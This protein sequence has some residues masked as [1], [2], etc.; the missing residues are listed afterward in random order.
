MAVHVADAVRVFG[1]ASRLNEDGA[2]Y[3]KLL[4]AGVAVRLVAD[5]FLLD[6]EVQDPEVLG[7]VALMTSM[8]ESRPFICTQ[9][10]ETDNGNT[11]GCIYLAA[12]YQCRKYSILDVWEFIPPDPT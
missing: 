10:E 5:R 6:G 3:A 7:L 11:V 2:F 4:S 12:F 9:R 8:M 1:N